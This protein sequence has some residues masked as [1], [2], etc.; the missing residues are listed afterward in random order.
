MP[1]MA[2]D[3]IGHSGASGGCRYGDPSRRGRSIVNVPRFP[4]IPRNR[5][6]HDRRL[7]TFFRGK[8]KSQFDPGERSPNGRSEKDDVSYLPSAPPPAGRKIPSAPT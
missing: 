6:Q 4:N 2:A 5:R 1:Y 8:Q 3:L 7:S